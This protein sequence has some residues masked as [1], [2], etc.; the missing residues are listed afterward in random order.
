MSLNYEVYEGIER[1]VVA[2]CKFDDTQIS[3]KNE[4]REL[5]T[6]NL[7]LYL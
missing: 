7:H 5:L 6:Y 4:K 1:G 2:F 3:P